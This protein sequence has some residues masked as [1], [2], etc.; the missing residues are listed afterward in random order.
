MLVVWLMRNTREIEEP[1]GGVI[2]WGNDK[3]SEHEKKNAQ[4]TEKEKKSRKKQTSSERD[5]TKRHIKK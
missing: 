5:D 3:K 4:D 1:S 2:T